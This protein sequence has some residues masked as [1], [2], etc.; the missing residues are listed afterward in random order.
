MSHFETL[1][2]DDE[3]DG[4]SSSSAVTEEKIHEETRIG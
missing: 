2:T 1:K 3:R 4:T